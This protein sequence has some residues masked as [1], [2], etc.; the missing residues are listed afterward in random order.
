MQ[1]I[2]HLQIYKYVAW[3]NA[4]P[5]AAS[6]L[7][8]IAAIVYGEYKSATALRAL[9]SEGPR[10]HGDERRLLARSRVHPWRR[11]SCFP[12]ADAL[13]SIALPV[14]IKRS[15]LIQ[16]EEADLSD[17]IKTPSRSLGS[18]CRGPPSPLGPPASL[19]S[20]N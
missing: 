8:K 5:P 7:I 17:V 10:R 20:L 16:W 3:S 4:A 19:L 13:A 12:P 11:I 15:I 1:M 6:C 2:V 9:C 14:G 18:Y